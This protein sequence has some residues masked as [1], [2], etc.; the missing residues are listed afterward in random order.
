MFTTHRSFMERCGIV[1]YKFFQNWLRLGCGGLD[2]YLTTL[3]NGHSY[4]STRCWVG[5][6]N[7][8]RKS[9][10]TLTSPNSK[11]ESTFRPVVNPIL[12]V[13]GILTFLRTRCHKDTTIS[14]RTKKFPST[15]GPLPGPGFVSRD[16]GHDTGLY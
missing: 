12:V 1:A 13:I 8:I 3:E 4:G 16:L 11:S 14:H 7:F 9:S 15:M 10:T 2:R 5:K 6:E